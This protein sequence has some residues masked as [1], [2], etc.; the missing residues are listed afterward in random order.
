MTKTGCSN[1]TQTGPVNSRGTPRLCCS[2]A[3][4]RKCPKC[5]S[6]ATRIGSA[7]L[8]LESPDLN[9][10]PCSKQAHAMLLCHLLMHAFWRS[11]TQL[12]CPS[13][14]PA[15]QITGHVVACRDKQQS[16]RQDI[17]SADPV[18]RLRTCCKVG[19]CVGSLREVCAGLQWCHRA[20]TLAWQAHACHTIW[21]SSSPC[22]A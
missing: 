4:Q 5:C 13:G 3:A 22:T 1:S 18:G 15:A 12:A 6:T 8:C 2:P 21:R 19:F 7:L 9:L 11:P 16:H 14:A 20:A 17:V 10:S